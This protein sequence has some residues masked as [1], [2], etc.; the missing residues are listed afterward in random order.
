MNTPMSS[1]L[2]SVLIANYNNGKYLMDAID[3]VR[4]QTYNH[5]EIIL[6]DDGSTDDSVVLYDQLRQ[7]PRIHIYSNDTNQGCGFTK[8]RCAELAQGELCGFLDPD[9]A[10]TPDAL[11]IMVEAYRGREKT[12]ALFCARHYICDEKL[13]ILNTTI[14]DQMPTEENIDYL[15]NECVITHFCAFNRTSYERTDG[16]SSVMRRAVDQDLYLKL[17]E[18]GKKCF[19]NRALY[20]YRQQAQSISLGKNVNKALYWHIVAIQNACVRRKL[21]AETETLIAELIYNS[22]DTRQMERMR[23]LYYHPSYRYLLK[24]FWKKMCHA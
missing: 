14:A 18:V 6:V 24:M 1:P 5:W 3:S 20:L 12:H 10:L 13:T 23:K 2:F 7:D 11:Q 17:E 21:S 9:D 22:A 16:I 4:Q 15:H 8:R 19:I